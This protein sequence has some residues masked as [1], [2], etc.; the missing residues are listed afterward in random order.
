[1]VATQETKKVIRPEE[2]AACI[3]GAVTFSEYKGI[4]EDTGFVRIEGSDESHPIS[5]E[6]TSKGLDVKSVTWKAT[7]PA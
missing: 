2:W 7:K 6:M 4:L 1:M 5:E 3:A